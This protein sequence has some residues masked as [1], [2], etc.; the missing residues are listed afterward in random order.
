M[1]HCCNVLA[2]TLCI[3]HFSFDFQIVS[4]QCHFQWMIRTSARLVIRYRS[5]PLGLVRANAYLNSNIGEDR[6]ERRWRVVVGT[7]Q[8]DLNVYREG[9]YLFWLLLFSWCSI[10]ELSL[11]WS[12]VRGKA[13]NNGVWKKWINGHSTSSESAKL[14]NLFD[15]L[16]TIWVSESFDWNCSSN[17]IWLFALHLLRYGSTIHWHLKSVQHFGRFITR[18]RRW[19]H[20]TNEGVAISWLRCMISRYWY[21]LDPIHQT[22][23]FWWFWFSRPAYIIS[24]T[25]VGRWTSGSE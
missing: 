23:G 7:F 5:A 17:R 6:R 8:C 19:W 21:F 24:K 25:P 13:E 9:F 11:S 12:L 2:W 14:G 16:Q 18:K 10:K 1:N 20:E 3:E 15:F 4:R 22:T